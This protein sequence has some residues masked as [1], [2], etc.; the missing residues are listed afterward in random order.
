MQQ[1]YQLNQR[2]D[3]RQACGNCGK[4]DCF[5]RPECP[6]RNRRCRNCNSLGHFLLSV[7]SLADLIMN[8]RGVCL[9]KI[10]PRTGVVEKVKISPFIMSSVVLIAN[11]MFQSQR[12]RQKWKKYHPS[13]TE[14]Q[15]NT[16]ISRYR[17]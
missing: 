14:W 11:V 5:D 15:E 1:R 9:S 2:N 3:S 4:S 13:N 12:Q 10:T 16:C 7:H 17:S 6:A 8:N